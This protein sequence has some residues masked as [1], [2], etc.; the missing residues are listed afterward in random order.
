M[1]SSLA[2][3][4]FLK[5]LLILVRFFTK[6]IDILIPK[7]R[8][9]YLFAGSSGKEFSGNSYYLFASFIHHYP[10]ELKVYWLFRDKSLLDR[11]A[12]SP[13]RNRMIYTYSLKGLWYI[14]RSSYIF[15]THG[16]F[17]IS[18]FLGFKRKKIVHLF[19]AI[20]VKGLGVFFRALD[21][22]GKFLMLNECREYGYFTCASVFEKHAMMAC[23]QLSDAQTVV[24]GNPRN[25]LFFNPYLQ[26]NLDQKFPF[27]QKRVILYAPT[28][29]E[30]GPT[31]FFPF[32]DFDIESLHQF[33]KENET[34]LIIRGHINEGDGKEISKLKKYLQDENSMIKNGS[35]QMFPDG[36]ELLL[37]SDIVMTD[38][39]SIYMDFLLLDRPCIFLPYDLELYT[40]KRGM[41]YDY[42]TITPGPKVYTQQELL[43]A[44]KNYIENPK[45]DSVDR[46]RVMQTFH[47]YQDGK[48]YQRIYELLNPAT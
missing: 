11:H 14:F 32:D 1:T 41:L 9:L 21:P 6:F 17:D 38:Y 16:Q 47:Q 29:R 37:H 44:W 36:Q 35:S 22:F 18:P 8:K 19:H 30:Y 5:T 39:S 2:F 45:Q 3:K 20:C 13:Y 23:Y 40:E 4:Y 24:T 10:E 42:P 25:D 27:L 26:T 15:I 7:D 28:F 43:N 34:Y 12:S 31:R 48:A 33:L 46:Q